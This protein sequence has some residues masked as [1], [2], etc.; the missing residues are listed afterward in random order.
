MQGE[1]Q[2]CK[3]EVALVP[4]DEQKHKGAAHDP[5]SGRYGIL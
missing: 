2:G 3:I 5:D 1:E 4:E